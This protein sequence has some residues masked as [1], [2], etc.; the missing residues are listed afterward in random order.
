MTLLDRFFLSTAIPTHKQERLVYQ[1]SLS[2]KYAKFVATFSAQLT[3][4]SKAKPVNFFNKTEFY[5]KRYKYV[6]YILERIFTK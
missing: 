3:D 5:I 2:S 4:T 1:R 6:E